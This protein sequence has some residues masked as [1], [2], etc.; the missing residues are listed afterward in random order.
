MKAKVVIAVVLGAVLGA[1]AS[2]GY[3]YNR[4]MQLVRRYQ[5]HMADK[6]EEF[7]LSLFKPD[8]LYRLKLVD[9][10]GQTGTPIRNSAGRVVS[11]VRL[12]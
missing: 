1:G 9:P 4:E 6:P 7:D 8:E 3:I 2:Y 12:S 10:S 11:A 5:K